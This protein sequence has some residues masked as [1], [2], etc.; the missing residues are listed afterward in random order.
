MKTPIETITKYVETC[1]TG[2]ADNL[3][4]LFA[5]GAM[6]CGFFNGEFYIGDPDIFFDEVRN[7]PCPSASGEE[8]MGEIITGEVINKIAN[9][10]LEETNYLGS[11]YTILFQLACIDDSWLIVSKTYID[12]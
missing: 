1:R 2:D 12:E 4:K 3:K 11:D 8:Y 9:V 7:E 5:Q 6:M 10:T